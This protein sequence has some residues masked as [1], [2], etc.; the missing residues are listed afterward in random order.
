MI[1]ALTFFLSSIFLPPFN[2][3]RPTYP[4]YDY[5]AARAHEIK[6]HRRTIPLEGIFPGSI[7][8][9]LK[10]IV[11]PTG[12][13]IDAHVKGEEILKFWHE[14]KDEVRGWKFLP[15]KPHG[16]AVTVEVEEYIDLVP[17]ERLPTKHVVPPVIRPDSIVKIMLER[18]PCY[19]T[20]PSYT[21]TVATDGILFNGRNF[22]S[23]TGTR[24]GTVDASAVR[25]LAENFIAADFY[26][27]DDEYVSSVTD[28]PAYSLSIDIDGQSKKVLDYVGASQGMP[29]VIT[30]LKNEVDAFAR[31]ERWVGRRKH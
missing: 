8:L 29:A 18:T 10:L 21:V 19:G 4:S 9:R 13:V 30:E 23:F 11:S 24:R 1:V 16:K 5:R 17:P 15:F 27:M 3:E 12:D 31:T 14:V 25:R 7:H 2:D 20:C 6:P 26:S 22:V 28:N